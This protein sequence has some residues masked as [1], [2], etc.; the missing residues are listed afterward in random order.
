MII[1]AGDSFVYGSELADCKDDLTNCVYGHSLHTFAALLAK[2]FECIA[3]PGYGNDS[4][5]RTTIER[6]EQ[7]GVTG[8]IVSWTFPGR[9]EF[10]FNYNTEQRKSPWYTITPWTVETNLSNIEKEF[11]TKNDQ[12]LLH[13]SKHIERAKKTGVQ[14]FAQ[15][16]YQHVGS[17]EYWEIYC[18]LKEIVYLQNYLKIQNIPYLFTCADNSIFYN[19]TINN[20]DTVISSLYK[21]IDQDK[22]F[23]FPPGNSAQQTCEPRGFYQWAMENK[24][25]IGTTHPLE[26]A[27]LD[28]SKLMQRKFNEL[29]KKYL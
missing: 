3:W 17:S 27:H 19:Y 15:I 16:F 26:Q 8:V 10:R 29:V 2:D 20:A 25:P 5:A 11:I 7:G 13:Q 22:W 23:W 1:V 9:F 28:A 4:I 12:V 18:T 14:E 21:Q 6:C 24:Y